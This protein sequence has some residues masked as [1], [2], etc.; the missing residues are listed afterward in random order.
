MVSSVVVA[1]GG[2]WEWE[3]LSGS[4]IMGKARQIIKISPTRRVATVVFRGTGGAQD[5]PS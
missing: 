2:G 4:P 5:N 3:C 1:G